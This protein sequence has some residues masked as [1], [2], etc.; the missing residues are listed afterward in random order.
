MCSA[1]LFAVIVS[2]TAAT[3][4]ARDTVS[5]LCHSTCSQ[6]FVTRASVCLCV[7]LSITSNVLSCQVVEKYTHQLP[8]SDKA[9]LLAYAL[10]VASTSGMQSVPVTVEYTATEQY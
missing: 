4:V 1:S 7:Y 6:Y 10:E 8:S 3:G 5:S 2:L 9:E